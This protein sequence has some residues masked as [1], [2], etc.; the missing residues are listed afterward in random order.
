MRRR[1]IWRGLKGGGVGKGRKRRWQGSSMRL[2]RYPSTIAR[3]CPSSTPQ[4]SSL[5]SS[6]YS[7]PSARAQSPSLLTS[8]APSPS[9]SSPML[10]PKPTSCH[11]PSEASLIHQ[12]AASVCSRPQLSSF[13]QAPSPSPPC[14]EAFESPSAA[15]LAHHKG[16]FPLGQPI[17]K[18]AF[19]AEEGEDPVPP[20]F[21]VRDRLLSSFLPRSSAYPLHC[22]CLFFSSEHHS[23][24]KRSR[25]RFS[26]S[27]LATPPSRTPS[28]QSS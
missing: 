20:C 24:V 11:L 14:I 12:E 4:V 28:T 16:S 25:P 22:A 10:S 23:P 1:W 7:Q 9:P 8:A 27:C 5:L 18:V 26:S 2:R 19:C 13:A 3:S 21:Y 6:C 15:P 17:L